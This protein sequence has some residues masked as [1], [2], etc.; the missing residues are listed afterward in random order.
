M[1]GDIRRAVTIDINECFLPIPKP[2]V[3]DWL[4]INEESGQTVQE[5]EEKMR[6]LPYPR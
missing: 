4:S 3:D 1:N 2:E 6:I 5:F